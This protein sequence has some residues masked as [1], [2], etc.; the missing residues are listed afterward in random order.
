MDFFTV[1]LTQIAEEYALS[2][3]TSRK[4]PEYFLTDFT[5]LIFLKFFFS[6]KKRNTI[7][8]RNS[9]VKYNRKCSYVDMEIQ[10][11]GMHLSGPI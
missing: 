9:T 5:F 2:K 3:K 7:G 1:F 10:R 8:R 6:L 4:K 11:F